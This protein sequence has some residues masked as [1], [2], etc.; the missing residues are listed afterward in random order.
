MTNPYFQRQSIGTSS[1]WT[2]QSTSSTP[3]T[4]TSFPVTPTSA[5][6]DPFCTEEFCDYED[7][8][9]SRF[10]RVNTLAGSG[11]PAGSFDRDPTDSIRDVDGTVYATHRWDSTQAYGDAP[12]CAGPVVTCIAPNTPDTVIVWTKQ[13]KCA[14]GLL[15]TGPAYIKFD[16]YNNLWLIYSTC[17]ANG[18]ASTA[19]TT[20]L[21][22]YDYNVH[23][24]RI[25]KTTGNILFFKSFKA[26]I[27]DQGYSAK[28]LQGVVHDF[29]GNWYI[30]SSHPIRDNSWTEGVNEM[31]TGWIIKLNYNLNVQWGA[32]WTGNGY[33]YNYSTN[34]FYRSVDAPTEFITMSYSNNALYISSEVASAD[35]RVAPTFLKID[36]STGAF[37]QWPYTSFTGESGFPAYS[38]K[39]IYC[40]RG[41]IGFDSSLNV[42]A[43]CTLNGTVNTEINVLK[44]SATGSTIWQKAF[45]VNDN[46]GNNLLNQL[47][48]FKILITKGDRIFIAANRTAFR[49][50]NHFAY[51]VEITTSGTVI[52]TRKYTNSAA[53]YSVLQQLVTYT[54][55]P[56]TLLCKFGSGDHVDTTQEVEVFSVSSADFPSNSRTM[57]S[58]SNIASTSFTGVTETRCLPKLNTWGSVSNEFTPYT[59][60]FT[61][62]APD[63]TTQLFDIAQIRD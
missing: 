13:Y 34:A 22:T 10:F 57:T 2:Y 55:S 9:R 33:A 61:A 27:I 60:S 47:G 7:I 5:D 1:D 51:I 36:T 41:C 56:E 8:Y 44:F 31:K 24:L 6:G 62:P 23:F 16:I 11:S 25:S 30:A 29:S 50:G 48:Q 15:L 49:N 4:S 35:G 18:T 43:L 32:R 38:Q 45:S 63:R 58:L 46:L 37:I 17:S 21:G 28:S 42:Y 12:Y 19:G 53:A 54:Y 40:G 52:S 14:D 20:A 39:N 26:Y 59:T 3:L